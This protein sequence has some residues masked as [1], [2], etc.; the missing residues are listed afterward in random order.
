MLKD[1]DYGFI[2]SGMSIQ[3]TSLEDTI[4][5]INTMIHNHNVTESVR[6]SGQT[7]D[8]DYIRYANMKGSSI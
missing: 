8:D 2:Q 1:L 3:P 6:L 4:E 5:T 7:F